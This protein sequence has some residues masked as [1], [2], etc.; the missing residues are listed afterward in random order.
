MKGVIDERRERVGLAG[1]GIQ[2]KEEQNLNRQIPTGTTFEVW[3]DP[4]AADV[5]TQG[6]SLR[7]ISGSIDLSN[8]TTSAIRKTLL[9]HGLLII[10]IVHWFWFKQ[11]SKNQRNPKTAARK[12][13]RL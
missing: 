5:R 3:Y 6:R 10:G 4:S 8:A 13:L 7:V 1:F 11:R 9:C 12:S 2:A